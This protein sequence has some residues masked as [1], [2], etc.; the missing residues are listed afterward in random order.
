MKIN[1]LKKSVLLLGLP[2]LC[3][4]SCG[5]FETVNTNQLY[6]TEKERGLD[7]LASGGLFPA[8]MRSIIP[9]GDGSGTNE[10]NSY[11]VT[12]DMTCDNWAGYFSPG[13]Y[14]W[15]GGTSTPNYYFTVGRL[16]GIFKDMF[17]NSNDYLSIKAA[18]HEIVKGNNGEIEYRKKGLL[19]QSIYS[20]AQIVKI[21]GVH[22]ATDMFGPI[23]YSQVKPG[24]VRAPYDPQEDIYRS[25]FKELETA[26]E[27]LNNYKSTGGEVIVGL[28]AYDPIY[29]GQTAKWIKLG[30]SLM[31]RLAMRV[32]YADAALATEYAK[33]ATENRG[34]LMTD[35]DDTAKLETNGNFKFSN[36]LYTLWNAYGEVKM[37]A[38]IYSYLKGYSDPRLPK[39]FQGTLSNVKAVRLGVQSGDYTNFTLPNIQASTPT[40]WM[41]ASEVQ[42]L[43]AEAALFNLVSGSA[44]DYYQKGVNLSFAEYG[45]SSSIY[46][47]NSAQPAPYQDPVNGSN[48]MAALSTI[49]RKWDDNATQEENLERIIT[50][51]YIAIFPDGIEAWTEWRRTGYPRLFKEVVNLTNVSAKSITANGKDGGMRRF[52]FT[53]DEQKL[54]GENLA[55]AKTYLSGPDN[56][57]T[58]VWW[59][60]K[61]KN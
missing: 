10:V 7:G 3:L 23:P 12:I 24:E 16:N 8:F 60:K 6:P 48:N 45:V 58:P 20:V 18:T 34:G 37:G 36:S 59:D 25:F 17:K 13:K 39:Y 61:S 30:N 54:N 26:V 2:L 42:F 40:Y 47:T 4:T 21:M 52:P 57:S 27:T 53:D 9:T 5:D 11:Q 22:R 41:K 29:Q 28:E 43:L 33:K 1:K 51:K 56:A 14:G 38:S 19:D 31:L 50:Q 55:K 35:K 15:N 46:L 49:D 32:R 44:K